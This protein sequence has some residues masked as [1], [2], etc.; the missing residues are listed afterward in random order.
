MTDGDRVDLLLQALDESAV[1]LQSF[2]EDAWAGH[3][4]RVRRLVSSRDAH[5]LELIMS[6][7]GGMGSFGDV[8][9]HPS[10]GHDIELDDVARVNAQLKTL[11]TKLS[12]LAGGLM[13][14]LAVISIADASTLW[15]PQPFRRRCPIRG[16]KRGKRQCGRGPS[17]RVP[18]RAGAGG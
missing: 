2:G 16:G 10:N 13:R 18:Q 7:L 9:V 14:E 3:L 11:R 8:L 12:Q 4:Q 1:L 5:G 6:S 15:R 17:G